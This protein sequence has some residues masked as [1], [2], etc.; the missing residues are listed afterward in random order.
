MIDPNTISMPNGRP[1]S[2][3]ASMSQVARHLQGRVPCLLATVLTSDAACKRAIS[4][5]RVLCMPCRTRLL[6]AGVSSLTF[7]SGRQVVDVDANE[8]TLV[9][10]LSR[11]V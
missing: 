1:V 9:D 11:I 5:G 8:A 6:A 10:R 4:G 2:G 3:T 7:N